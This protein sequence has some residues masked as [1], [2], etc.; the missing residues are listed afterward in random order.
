MEKEIPRDE[1]PAPGLAHRS[2]AARLAAPA[3]RHCLSC[4][5]LAAPPAGAEP[6]S[7]LE[8]L[9]KALAGTRVAL[10]GGLPGYPILGPL[11]GTG[12]PLQK[13]FGSS[14]PQ[15]RHIHSSPPP[16]NP[17]PILQMRKRWLKNGSCRVHG[18]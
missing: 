12:L 11:H 3:P 2:G 8:Q 1:R 14:H 7:W 18:H 6:L 10:P 16:R 13:G 5:E 4:G 15:R 17:I 9:K